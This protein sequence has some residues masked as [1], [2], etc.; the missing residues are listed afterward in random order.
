MVINISGCWLELELSLWNGR[1]CCPT[2]FFPYA[3]SDASRTQHKTDWELGVNTNVYI[4]G[5][6]AL[7][8]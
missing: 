2:H 4:E 3:C 6:C 1:I 5:M 8:H 7:D